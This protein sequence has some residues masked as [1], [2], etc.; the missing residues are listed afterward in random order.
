M[1]GVCEQANW[2]VKVPVAAG[3]DP[4][5]AANAFAA[6]NA[7]LLVSP[8]FVSA[9]RSSTSLL[10]TAAVE[11]STVESAVLSVTPPAAVRAGAKGPV[12]L[13]MALS[14][15]CLVSS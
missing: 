8:V 3:A 15:L 4:V 5:G 10:S 12:G 13:V 9:V 11:T 7:A 1:W 2:D 6:N 14:F